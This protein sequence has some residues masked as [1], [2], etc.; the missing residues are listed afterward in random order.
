MKNRKDKVVCDSKL[1]FSSV[2]LVES[3]I[4]EANQVGV[5]SYY[6][7]KTCNGY[8]SFTLP[9]KKKVFEKRAYESRKKEFFKIKKFKEKKDRRKNR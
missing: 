5:L 3:H 8:H 4:S 1:R 2:E 7:C 9:D 6:H